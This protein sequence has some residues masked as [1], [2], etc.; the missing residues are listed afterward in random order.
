[1][2]KGTGQSRWAKQ[3][4][5]RL[6]RLARGVAMADS[7]LTIEVRWNGITLEARPY[8]EIGWEKLV[9]PRQLRLPRT[10][11]ACDSQ[12]SLTAF[13]LGLFIA[14]AARPIIDAWEREPIPYP[15]QQA[16]FL[17]LSDLN[18]APPD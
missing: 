15:Q 10:K 13:E 18:S 4:V 11:V 9:G 17:D 6:T 7:V 2:S 12:Q 8:L 14:T 5:H 3:L 16:L 1:M